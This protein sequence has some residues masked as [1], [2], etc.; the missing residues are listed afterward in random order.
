MCGIGFII[1]YDTKNTINLDMA[2]EMFTA[3]NRRG[4]EASGIYLERKVNSIIQRVV[5]K[6]PIPSD[7]LWQLTQ[8]DETNHPELKDIK[9]TGHERLVMF[10]TRTGTTGSERDNNNNMPIYSKNYILI[11][12]GVLYADKEKDYPYMGEV[13]SEAILAKTESSNLKH[14]ITSIRGSMAIA[15]KK[16]GDPFLFVYR[17]ANPLY[18]V[19]FQHLNMLFGC[20]LPEYVPHIERQVQRL[21][22]VLFKSGCTIVEV[23][24]H[25]LFKIHIT[26]KSIEHEGHFECETPPSTYAWPSK[27]GVVT[28]GGNLT[29][30]EVR[31]VN[32]EASRLLG[33]PH[34]YSSD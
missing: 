26:R 2:K 16:L 15:I 4:T 29:L 31:A 13:D 9:L 7:K 21:G 25:E 30:A 10:H 6:S 23:P 1:N 12:N 24:E 8:L 18:L 14:A 33:G 34:E 3:M 28:A 27:N 32:A 17:R 11:H 19:Y 22:T 5:F 20:S